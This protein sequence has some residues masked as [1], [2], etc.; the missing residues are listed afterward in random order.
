MELLVRM[1]WIKDVLVASV[2][3]Y[4]HLRE[5]GYHGD[6][7]GDTGRLGFLLILALV[8]IFEWMGK[9]LE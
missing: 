3:V 8:V 1:L 5:D 2:L 4:A 7:L 6:E 9:V